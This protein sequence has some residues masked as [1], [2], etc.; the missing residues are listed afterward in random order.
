M[1]FQKKIFL[2]FLLLAISVTMITG[3]GSSVSGNPKGSLQDAVV[4]FGEAKSYNYSGSFTL[5][6]DLDENF[7]ATDPEAA[8]GLAILNSS[9]INFRGAQT[10]E[11]FQAEFELSTEVDYQG[12]KLSIEIPIFMNTE[13]MWIKV[14][15]FLATFDPTFEALSGKYVELNFAELAEM[16]GEEVPDLAKEM[17]AQM[18]LQPKL[19]EALISPYEKDYFTSVKTEDVTLPTGV[20]T[21]DIVK[22]SITNENLA[23][24][25]TTAIDEV[26]PKMM[27]ILAESELYS[28]VPEI[29]TE[30]ATAKEELAASKEEFLNDLE[31]NKDTFSINKFDLLFGIKD[32]VQNFQSIDLDMNFNDAGETH[33][34]KLQG[35]IYVTNINKEPEFKYT[36]PTEEESISL[37]QLM[38]L[39]MG[40]Y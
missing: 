40:A 1:K 24:F 9:V 16:S 4:K 38:G 8:E 37:F 32:G 10:L 31:A 13:A 15:E 14:P 6:F 33:A 3:C 28:D 17:K 36:V 35:H 2:L 20:D 12:L 27:D 18:E 5:N 21:K 25:L 30:L 7:L 11:P 26:L 39:F 29:K 19:V 22:V 34:V 23:A